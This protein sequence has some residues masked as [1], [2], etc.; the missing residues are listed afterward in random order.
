MSGQLAKR[1][2]GRG[3]NAAHGETGEPRGA[4]A[5]CENIRDGRDRDVAMGDTVAVGREPRIVAKR[6]LA[7]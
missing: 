6:R 2:D 5:A 4:T 3:R 1:V 7:R